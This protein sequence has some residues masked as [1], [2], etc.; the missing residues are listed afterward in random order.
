MAVSK[1]KDR[2][3]FDQAFDLD[4]QKIQCIFASAN[5]GY[6]RPQSRLASELTEKDPAARVAVQFRHLDA[7]VEA[8]GD[9]PDARPILRGALPRNNKH[10]RHAKDV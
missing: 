5:T 9:P 2:R 4:P 3:T 8:K 1:N 10:D 6:V 7:I